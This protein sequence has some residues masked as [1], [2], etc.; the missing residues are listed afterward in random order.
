VRGARVVLTGGGGFIGSRL[1][2]TLVA[3]GAEVTLVGPSLGKSATT[4]RLVD[5]GA[6]RFVRCGASSRDEPM[7]REALRSAELLVLLGYVPPTSLDPERR[8]LEE[9]SLNVSA[10]LEL[11]D[12]TSDDLRHV[13]FS[14]SVS[15]YGSPD[16]AV[17]DESDA[18]RPQTP[19]ASAKL[20][21]EEALWRVATERQL[22]L[23]VLRYATVYGPGE[24]VPRAIPNFIRSALGGTPLSIDGDGLDE[25]DYVFVDDVVDATRAALLRRATGIYNVGTGIGTTTLDVARLVLGLASCDSAV[26]HRPPRAGRSEHSRLVCAT[27]RARD[28]LGFSARWRLADGVQREIAWFSNQPSP[29]E[30]REAALA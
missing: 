25:N 18:G 8:T 9:L 29:L 17:V 26:E 7:L 24:T 22:G 6:A 20:A 13:L 10:N 11:L 5:E 19:Y 23:T 16:R 21:C 3:D 15:V 14:S 30:S 2:T 1:L 27:Q 28:G 12:L 4:A